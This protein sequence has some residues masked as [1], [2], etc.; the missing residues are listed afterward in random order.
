MS[1]WPSPSYPQF[2]PSSLSGHSSVHPF[3]SLLLVA[4]LSSVRRGWLVF[5]EHFS[6]NSLLLHP[7][8]PWTPTEPVELAE[9]VTSS[10]DSAW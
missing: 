3:L 9:V 6:Y 2:D 1:P 5:D 8:Y 4:I 7:R 10:P